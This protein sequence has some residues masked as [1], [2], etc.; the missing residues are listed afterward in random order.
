MAGLARP[1]DIAADIARRAEELRSGRVSAALRLLGP[2]PLWHN[3]G[4]VGEPSY[5]PGWSAESPG[6]APSYLADSAGYV[7]LRG[8]V[9]G[10]VY[11]NNSSL[12]FVMFAEHRP[13]YDVPLVRKA[14]IV[15]GGSTEVQIQILAS[16]GV[17]I[18]GIANITVIFDL[19]GLDYRL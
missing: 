5:Q 1:F 18:Q 11:A 14:Y 13:L 9:R 8:P 4:A 19:D 17:E 2:L 7:H 16:G 3:F 15:G 6:A 10:P 12:M